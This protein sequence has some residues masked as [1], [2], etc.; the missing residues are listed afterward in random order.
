MNLAFDRPELMLLAVPALFAAW[1]WR[2]RRPLAD[3]TRVTA[4][5]LICCALIGPSVRIG[6]DGRDLIAVIDRS[7]SMLADTDALARELIGLLEE[8]RGEHQ[9]LGVVSF[10]ATPRAEHRPDTSARFLGFSAPVDPHASDLRSAIDLAM[11]L[12]PAGR[13]ARVLVFSDGE[14]TGTDP[15]TA[16]R[17]ARHRGIEITT[18]AAARPPGNDLAA[19]R[20]ELP[21]EVAH[22]EPFQFA[23]WVR[24]D[25]AAQVRWRLLVGGVE[26][27]TDTAALDAGWNRIALRDRPERSGVINYRFELLGAHDGRPEND[28]TLGAVR[29]RGET[30]VLVLNESGQTSA[31]VEALRS[32][33]LVVSARAP[34]DV[35]LDLLQLERYSAV[36]LENVSAARVGT[37]T[38]Q[39][40]ERYVR[41]RGR[42]LLMTGGRASFARGG[43]WRSALDPALTVDLDPRDEDRRVGVALGMALDRSGSMSAPAGG[44]TKMDLA[45]DGAARA[46]ELL[47]PGDAVALIAVDTSAHVIVPL[48]PVVDPVALAAT[49]RRVDSQGGGIFVLTALQALIG[50][51]EGS[52]Q[53]NRHMILFADAS[54]SEEQEGCVELARQ[55]SA[56]GAVLSVIA[57]GTDV[58]SDAVFLR[59]L[60]AAGKGQAWFTTSATELPALFAQEVAEATRGGLVEER[61]A[62]GARPPLLELG[63]ELGGPAAIGGHHLG[64]PRER[65][66]VAL[67]LENERRDPLLVFGHRGLGRSASY[68]GQVG[69]DLGGELVN[70]EGFA[71]LFSSLGR[72]LSADEPP[73]DTFGRAR[74]ERGDLI[75]EV[76]L[77]PDA[78]RTRTD[79]A[80]I[81]TLSHPFSTS[82]LTLERVA[83]DRYEGRTRLVEVGVH[84]VR[85]DLGA[86]EGLDLPPLVHS[87]S[88][89]HLVEGD[90]GRGRRTLDRLSEQTGA[91]PL[92]SIEALWDGPLGGSR[93]QP[94]AWLLA[95]LAAVALVTEIAARRLALGPATWRRLRLRRA[96]AIETAAAAAAEPSAE[97]GPAPNA[98]DPD[99]KVDT[100]RAQAE[101]L[102]K[103]RERRRRE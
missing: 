83:V 66:L 89:E 3:L 62:V 29:A 77:G 103:L 9:R 87:V 45:N 30:E 4:V 81:A 84:L 33:G 41:E 74:V 16:A 34:E 10:G 23:A 36:V 6:D 61:V 50:E 73:A 21:G 63:A 47:G 92:G 101:L 12:V 95:M 100:A 75:V 86:N 70:W 97:P 31:L 88:P 32:G 55:L 58:D 53:V 46:I 98:Q 90:P 5:A 42:G 40:L 15:L 20:L 85:I 39:A 43:W 25:A 71:P 2:P 80:L 64:R 38:S 72:W 68:L 19:A 52:T 37:R 99:L 78:A 28:T 79:S 24:A 57:L 27:A 8:S 94:F 48:S 22:G 96:T 60:A 65:M 69:G 13:P 76:E 35:S 49:A 56:A 51:L 102:A 67:A 26:R 7:E 54:D 59:E 11:E 82:Q 1:R 17:K 93:R 14:F 91:A 18:R 44:G